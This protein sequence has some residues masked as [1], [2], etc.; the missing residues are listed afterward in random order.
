LN[1]F[2]DDYYERGFEKGLSCYSNYRWIPELTIPMCADMINYLPIDEQ[3]TV[4]DYGCAKGYTVKAMRLLHREAFGV[5]ISEYAIQSVPP[6]VKDHCVLLGASGAIPLFKGVKYDWLIAKDVLEH[7]D[8][9]SLPGVL[10]NIRNACYQSFV[11][12]PLGADGKYEI[13]AYEL[14]VTHRIRETMEWWKQ[15]FESAGLAVTSAEYLVPHLKENW[16]GWKKGN[17]FFKLRSM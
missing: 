13:P 1:Q 9:C 12:V 5:D 4:L 6:E 2:N 7:V 14:D 17:G 11:I 8:Y 10:N 15:S 16:A 3:D